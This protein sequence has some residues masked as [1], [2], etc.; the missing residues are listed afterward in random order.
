MG[1]QWLIILIQTNW[2]NIIRYIQCYT[3]VLDQNECKST[4]IYF[5]EKSKC[6]F[7]CEERWLYSEFIGNISV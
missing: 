1:Y 2:S 5:Q 7:I 4:V 3:I 6:F